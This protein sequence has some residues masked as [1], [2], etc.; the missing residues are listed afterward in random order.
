MAPKERRKTIKT[1][2]EILPLLASAPFFANSLLQ[3]PLTSPLFAETQAVTDWSRALCD[4]TMQRTPDPTKLGGWGYAV[5]LYLYGQFLVYKRTGEKKYLDYIQGWVDKHVSEDGV[6]DRSISALDYMLPGNLLLVLY[7]ETK[8][9]KYRK[10]ADSI[11]HRLDTYPRTEDGGLWHALSRQH[12]LWLDGMFMSM[13]FLVRYGKAFQDETY[14]NDEAA[15][16]LLIYIKHLNDPA[17]GLMWHAYDESGAQ[18]WADPVTHHSSIFWCRAIGWF[19]MALIEVLEILPHNHR[20]AKSSSP[21]S[22]NSPTP[23]RS[24]RMRQPAFGIRS[25]TRGPSRE[26]G[27]K[28]PALPCIRTQSTWPSS[29]NTSPGRCSRSP[30]KA[31]AA[32]SPS[33]PSTPTDRP[34]SPTSAAEPTSE[35]STTTSTVHATQMTSTDSA[36]SSS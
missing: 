28:P 10:A 33:S 35:T 16:Q 23:M 11:R 31:I 18:P 20:N 32:C 1:R 17:T 15:K 21:R 6:I 8:Q 25:S 30:A 26:T 9:E 29:A 2:Q 34:T 22:F 12:Q 27:S 36:P 5:S 3:S 7:A 13:P 4:A 19:G 24:I 14:A